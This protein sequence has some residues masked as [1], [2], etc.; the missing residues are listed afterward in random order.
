MTDFQRL[1]RNVLREIHDHSAPHRMLFSYAKMEQNAA[2]IWDSLRVA[3]IMQRGLGRAQFRKLETVASRLSIAIT[4][5][6]TFFPAK[7]IISDLLVIR[8]LTRPLDSRIRASH[9][10]ALSFGW[11]ACLVSAS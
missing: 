4:S 8:S 3:Y 2:E 5:T 11:M 6:E 9:G 1:R 7:W 10:S